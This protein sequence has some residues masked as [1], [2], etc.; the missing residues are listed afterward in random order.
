[1]TTEKTLTLTFTTQK[2]DYIAQVLAARPFSEVAALI[3]D[4]QQQ[5]AAQQGMPAMGNGQDTNPP[6]EIRQ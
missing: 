6:Q 5:L 3:A 2:L 1:M 4:I